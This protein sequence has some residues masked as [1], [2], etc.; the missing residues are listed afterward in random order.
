MLNEAQGMSSRANPSSGTAPGVRA[1]PRTHLIKASCRLKT[2][3]IFLSSLYKRIFCRENIGLEVGVIV[4][5]ALHEMGEKREIN[6]KDHSSG[7]QIPK[8]QAITKGFQ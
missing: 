3:A 1:L 5:R 4:D 7:K 2:N 8:T 6:R